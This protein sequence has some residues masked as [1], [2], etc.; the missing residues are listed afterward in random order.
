MNGP[1][2]SVQ[3]ITEDLTTVRPA[4]RRLVTGRLIVAGYAGLDP[5]GQLKRRT[6]GGRRSRHAIDRTE[7]NRNW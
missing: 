2:L 3:L 6:A 5:A 7:E 4:L 1:I